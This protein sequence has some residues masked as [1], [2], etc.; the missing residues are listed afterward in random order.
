MRIRY[1]HRPSSP[2]NI[3]LVILLNLSKT[4]ASKLTINTNG[5]I[6]NSFSSSYDEMSAVT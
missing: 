5:L 4:G 3:Y 6:A 1:T 2:V